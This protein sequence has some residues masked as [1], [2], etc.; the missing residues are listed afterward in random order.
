MAVFWTTAVHSAMPEGPELH[1]ASVFVN[2]AC[3]GLIFSG[4]VEKSEVSKEAEVPFASD[5]Y[6]ISATSRGKKCGSHS[7]QSNLTHGVK[8]NQN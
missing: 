1:L 5:A 7:L 8:A 3:A 2:T 6:R 4:A